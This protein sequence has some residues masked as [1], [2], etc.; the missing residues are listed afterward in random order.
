MKKLIYAAVAV[1]A[2]AFMISCDSVKNALEETTITTT[3]AASGTQ[4]PPIPVPINVTG[5]V[6][7][8][9]SGDDLYQFSGSIKLTKNG[10]LGEQIAAYSK[11]QGIVINAVTL[12]CTGDASDGS[13][14]SDIV[15]TASGV[16]DFTYPGQFYFMGTPATPTDLPPFLTGV[17]AQLLAGNDVTLAVSGKTN[18]PDTTGLFIELT[19]TDAT[20]TVT[21]FKN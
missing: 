2:V 17:I 12:T 6:A 18:L 11:I 10:I 20:L 1:C 16:K 9:R 14:V 15:A 13:Y 21:P 8:A 4:I 3:L 5:P 7:S 19:I